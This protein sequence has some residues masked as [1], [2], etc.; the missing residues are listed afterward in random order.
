MRSRQLPLPTA[1][2][3]VRANSAFRASRSAWTTRA[4]RPASHDTMAIRSAVWS[5]WKCRPKLCSALRRDGLDVNPGVA[6][7]ALG[8]PVAGE[9]KTTT[10]PHRSNRRGAM[11]GPR[12]PHTQG[13][14]CAGEPVWLVSLRTDPNGC[15]RWTT[16]DLH[17]DRLARTPTD[18]PE[19]SAPRGSWVRAP[20]SR[21]AGC[22]HVDRSGLHDAQ[23]VAVVP[24]TCHIGRNA[25]STHGHSCDPGLGTPWSRST[26]RTRLMPRPHLHGRSR[27]FESLS[28]HRSTRRGSPGSLPSGWA[29]RHGATPT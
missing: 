15:G 3:D 16:S 28:A 22:S 10:S 5:F 13:L 24:S 20:S 25:T 14:S 19:C 21:T 11:S 1:V 17:S 7:Q 26:Q 4:V 29:S 12:R 27:G 2:A 9:P 23:A 6:Q 18:A 8:H